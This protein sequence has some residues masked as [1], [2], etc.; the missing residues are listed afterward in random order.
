MGMKSNLGVDLV[1]SV[2]SASSGG[3]G[4]GRWIP[5]TAASGRRKG[6]LRE[7]NPKPGRG[8]GKTTGSFRIS[9]SFLLFFDSLL[10]EC[11]VLYCDETDV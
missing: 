4:G 7:E 9:P 2:L 3:V 10:M 1:H 6:R 5:L 11:I 8:S